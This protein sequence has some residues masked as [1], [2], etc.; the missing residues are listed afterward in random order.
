MRA[1]NLTISIPNKG[2]D[3][4]CPYCISKITGSVKSNV[5]LMRR[6]TSKVKSLARA[7]QITSVLLTSKGE[8]CLNMEHTLEF[9]NEF[10]EW[11]TELQTNGE[12][13]LKDLASGSNSVLEQL[14]FAGLNVLAI[15]VDND[16]QMKYKVPL[17]TRCASELGMVVRL[18][19]NV[20]NMFTLDAY[21]IIDICKKFSIDQFTLRRISYPSNNVKNNKVIKWIQENTELSHYNDLNQSFLYGLDPDKDLIRHTSDG[22]SVWDKEGVSI[23]CS[24]YCIQ[25]SA[26]TEEVRS[27]I[28]QEDGHLYTS[29]NSK[30][31]VLF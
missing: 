21:E 7:A 22:I 15:S 19:L 4:N 2:C 27:L 30:A 13:I 14:F 11:P 1:N 5:D 9:L 17:V 10:N 16:Y 31:S 12:A 26:K 29:W 3:K 6:N 20:N 24:D 23:L 8:P 28:F 18:T 25:E